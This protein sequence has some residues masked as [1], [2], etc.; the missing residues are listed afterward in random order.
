MLKTVFGLAVLVAGELTYTNT[1]HKSVGDCPV[2]CE[3]TTLA[4]LN[5]CRDS[6]RGDNAT[7]CKVTGTYSFNGSSTLVMSCVTTV[8][9]KVYYTLALEG[10]ED[11]S[12]VPKSVNVTLQAPHLMKG[13]QLLTAPYSDDTASTC[14]VDPTQPTGV[15][16]ISLGIHTMGPKILTEPALIGTVYATST[17]DT[18][19][20]TLKD[21]IVTIN[22]VIV[23]YSY[24][25]L[26]AEENTPTDSVTKETSGSEANLLGSVAV[27][28]LIAYS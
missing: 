1:N 25:V 18:E 17:T 22:T 9:T 14:N 19:C 2:V 13:C 21:A 8:D 3:G 16:I 5:L 4:D 12:D 15:S 26:E 24:N 20:E 23:D 10:L 28:I 7:G 11:V 27:A 6:I